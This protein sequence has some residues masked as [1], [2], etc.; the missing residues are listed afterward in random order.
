MSEFERQLSFVSHAT[1]QLA[2]AEPKLREAFDDIFN[3]ALNLLDD[4]NEDSFSIVSAECLLLAEELFRRLDRTGDNL[5]RAEDF[6]SPDNPESDRM[7]KQFWEMLTKDF[8]FNGDRT[9]DPLEF[10]GHFIS[11]AMLDGS[12]AP[13]PQQECLGDHLLILQDQFNSAFMEDINIVARL[14]DLSLSPPRVKNNNF[15]SFPMLA[16]FLIKL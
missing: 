4:D 15:N 7:L 13:I 2:S 10:L 12:P 6:V 1:G 16:L 11:K 5:L 9:I 14:F 3:G 8:D